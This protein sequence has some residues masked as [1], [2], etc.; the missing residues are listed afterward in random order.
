M[1]EF[2]RSCS[3]FPQQSYNWISLMLNY[4]L[5][6]SR[7]L[8]GPVPWALGQTLWEELRE[9][10]VKPHCGTVGGIWTRCGEQVQNAYTASHGYPALSIG[11]L[12]KDHVSKQVC[13]PV[14]GCQTAKSNRCPELTPEAQS[15]RSV[16]SHSRGVFFSLTQNSLNLVIYFPRPKQTG[17]QK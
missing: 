9:G 13:W 3:D 8:R 14:S 12:E 7:Q 5:R 17:T 2:Y 6:P 1:N 10:E 11:C 16:E 15:K 4:N